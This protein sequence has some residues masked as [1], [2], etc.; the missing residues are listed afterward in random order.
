MSY[1][2]LVGRDFRRNKL[3]MLATLLVFSVA[4]IAVFAPLIAN[5]RPYMIEAIFKD[6]YD[7][8]YFQV[9]DYA[10]RM[11]GDETPEAEDLAG[12]EASFVEMRG[13]L[14][15]RHHTRLADLRKLF[16]SLASQGK[17]S[18]GDFATALGEFEEE[19]DLGVVTLVKQKRHPAFRALVPAEIFF[20][21][22]YLLAVPSFFLRK[23]L[24]TVPRFLMVTLIPA[25]LGTWILS[26]TPHVQVFG[27]TIVPEMW[28]GVYP[29]VQDT[30]P[31]R[32]MI[33]SELFESSGGRVVRALVPYGENENL[34]AESRQPPTFLLAKDKWA[35]GQ[36]WHWM[37]TDTNG[38]DVLSRMVYGARIS[39]L[40]GIV[41][42][43]IYVT[44]G[45]LL[46]ALA[47]FYGGWV[48][49]I[50]SRIIE[51]VICFPVLFLILSVQAFLKPSIINIMAALGLVWWTGVAR[52]QRG[53]FLRV[54]NL[55]F[56][57]AVR[58][59]GGSNLRI[60][61]L[62]VLPNALGPILVVISFGIAGSILIESGLSFLGFGVPQP[63]ASWGDLLNNGRADI[64]GTWWLTVFPG[65][66]I[67]LTVTCFN[68]MGEGIRDALDPR[69]DH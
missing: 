29:T 66:A 1:W 68:L 30:F 65:L 17:A 64:Q 44:I 26:G 49:L 19:F 5:N 55:D 37:G 48:D 2:E 36:H 62:H 56:V 9:L 51:I 54:V 60:I 39:M 40:V 20:M 63:T 8:A 21:F 23:R 57:Q 47:G 43:S 69:K 22:F 11:A 41:S 10:D 34:T 67:F 61:F 35:E 15:P 28:K 50:L 24:K 33:D 46:G 42:V 38:R 52:L 3:A 53:E 32:R 45:I 31:Y 27:K 25:F 4:T 6:S 59:L 16:T 13:H 18:S 58:A 12:L 14:D 7:N